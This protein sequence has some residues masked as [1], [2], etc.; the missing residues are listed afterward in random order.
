MPSSKQKKQFHTYYNKEEWERILQN[1]A[2]TRMKPATYIRWIS[3]FGEIKLYDTTAVEKLSLAINRYG[4]NLNQIAAVVNKSGSVYKADIDKLN[5]DIMYLEK[6]IMDRL[7][8]LK[9]NLI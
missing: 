4:N 6:Y 7:S 2:K 3:L 8:V 9:Y 5:T 1:A